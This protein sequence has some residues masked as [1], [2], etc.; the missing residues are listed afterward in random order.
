[1]CVPIA[2]MAVGAFLLC[3]LPALLVSCRQTS[4]K[5]KGSAAGD[6]IELRYARHLTLV[7][8]GDKVEAIIRNPWDTA[9]VLTRYLIDKPLKRAIVFSAVHCAL[10]EELGALD[11]IKG[12]CDAPYISSK[13]ITQAIKNGKIRDLGSSYQPNIELL[14]ATNPDAL[15]PSGFE[16][17]GSYAGTDRLGI[18][19]IPCVDYM[20]QGPLA[21]AE[22]MK[23][24]GRLV[25]KGAEADSLF[26]QVEQHYLALKQLA[27]GATDRP[28]LLSGY[29]YQGTWYVPGGQSSMGMLYAD[30]GVRYIYADTPAT[31]SLPMNIE[32]VLSEG[33]QAKIW[34]FVYNQPR[35]ITREQIASE[36]RLLTQFDAFNNGGLRAC[37]AAQIAFH[38]LTPFHPDFLLEDI[39][40]IAHPELG[41]KPRYEFY[42]EVN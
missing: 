3:F 41:V 8:R 15:L 42:K 19:L 23:F 14:A 36:N 1:M 31:G 11:C 20:E 24:F 9:K 4:P 26:N 6:T 40:A 34:L 12:V 27:E 30:A 29:P 28:N 38:E 33:H 7:Q 32:N 10:F 18:P 13:A 37:N 25:G 16:N 2:V 17:A 35:P 39:L 21:R 22:W 5:T